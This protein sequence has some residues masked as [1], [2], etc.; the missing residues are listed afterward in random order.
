[1][2][3]LNPEE[4]VLVLAAVMTVRLFTYAPTPRHAGKSVIFTAKNIAIYELYGTLLPET[5]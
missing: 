3:S 4:T 1:M 5:I 2:F